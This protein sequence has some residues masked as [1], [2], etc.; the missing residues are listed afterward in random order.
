ME[1]LALPRLTA[2]GH[3]PSRAAA[4]AATTTALLL[5]GFAIQMAVYAHGGHTAISD[6]PRVYLH[7]GMGTGV[8]PYVDRVLEYPVGAGLLMFVAAQVAPSAL[9]VFAVTA[10]GAA[11]LCVAITVAL[12]RHDG[13]RAWRWAIGV[14]VMLYAFQNWDVYAVALLLGG[15]F[16]FER[17]RDTTAGVARPRC[18]GEAVPRGG[19]AAARRARWQ[20]GDR[21]GA[22]RL[23][24]SAG[25]V[26]LVLNLPFAFANFGGWRWAFTFQGARQA[27]WGSAEFYVLRLV[28]A[29]VHGAT[30]SSLA[31]TASFV[32]MGV[33]LA[34]ITLLALRRPVT[35]VGVAGAAVAV[36]LL[37]NKV[38]SPTYDLWLLAFFVLL[39]VSHR[40][41]VAFCAVDAAVFVTV[42]GHFHWGVSSHVVHL[43]L[44]AL[45][46]VRTC[47]LVAFTATALRT[48][49]TDP[50]SVKKPPSGWMSS[51]VKYDA[52][53]DARKATALAISEG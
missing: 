6:L 21:R 9:G 29:S 48:R 30:G 15:L 39:P 33:G 18:R 8:V 43:V 40:L 24:A 11:A 23:V 19:G 37:T 32:V 34:T 7:R 28:G 1:A 3:A 14:P 5:A 44:P 27:T 31:N 46:A 51:P 4:M 38:F 22:I 50:Q 41:W 49:A 16:L 2:T 20:Q 47:V 45:V 25:A 52:S 42:Y 10:L 26:L 12:E 36:F 17:R 35:A 13:V 53:S